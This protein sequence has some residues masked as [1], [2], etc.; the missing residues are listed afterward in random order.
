[1][2]ESASLGYGNLA[3]AIAIG[4]TI[5]RF[6]SGDSSPASTTVA[7]LGAD[8]AKPPTAAELAELAGA[9]AAADAGRARILFA[10]DIMQHASQAADD[11]DASYAKVAPLLHDADLAVGNLEFPV[12]AT[13]PVGP[14]ERSVK[15]N[16]STAN[17]DALARAGFT[18]L[19]TSNNH[20]FDHGVDGMRATIVEVTKR[21]IGVVGTAAT[22]AEL[23]SR[24]VMRDVKGIR[25]AFLAYTGI[26]NTYLDDHERFVDP[27]PDVP[28]LFANFGEWEGDYRERGI[29][30]FREHVARARRDGAELVV[31][32][33]HWGKEWNFAPTRDQ[34][35]AGHDLIAA[36]FDLVVGGHGH[37]INSPEVYRGKLIVYSLGNFICDFSE[38]QARTGALLEVTVVRDAPGKARVTDFALKPLLV[39]REGHIVE[40][41][42]DEAAAA[43]G[44]PALAWDLAHR[45]FGQ[46]R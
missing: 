1:M 18:L 15:F 12:V 42:D 8:S 11:F 45:M 4:A 37:V 46:P 24:I 7:F 6:L 40:P 14:G 38:W 27:P 39:R 29:R 23:E 44:E 25:V 13:E 20:A 33:T 22:R 26:L 19:S 3:V 34:V 36:G 32:L 43:G 16:G 2:R 30:M 9:P 35:A 28:L 21:G 31:A 41:L 17:L 10:G 5:L